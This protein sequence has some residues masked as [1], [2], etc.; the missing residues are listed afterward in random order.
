MTVPF[1]RIEVLLMQKK[2]KCTFFLVGGSIFLIEFNNNLDFNWG[3]VKE[4]LNTRYSNK[5][6]MFCYQITTLPHK[7]S[8]S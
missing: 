5:L 1:P 3:S 2:P 6:L 8:Q 7:H 4:A